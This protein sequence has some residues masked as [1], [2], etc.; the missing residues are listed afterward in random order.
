[1]RTPIQQK[2]DAHKVAWNAFGEA[3]EKT[4]MFERTPE[5]NRTG[6]AEERAFLDLLA[7]PA[8][9][10]EARR[11]L[12]YVLAQLREDNF[13]ADER[14]LRALIRAGAAP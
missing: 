10:I 5:V 14:H 11:K 7:T 4:E 8:R 3:I 1:V 9:G 12:R 13:D 6:N 2:I